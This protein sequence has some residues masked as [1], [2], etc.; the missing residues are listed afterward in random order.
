MAKI[1]QRMEQLIALFSLLP[2]L[3]IKT[4]N[5]VESVINS[6]LH[7]WL[8]CQMFSPNILVLTDFGTQLAPLA[9]GS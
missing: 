9:Y 1:F 4:V 7:F 8:S 5:Q 6:S 2:R 3:V